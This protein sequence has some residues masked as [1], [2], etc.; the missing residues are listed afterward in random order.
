MPAQK[1]LDTNAFPYIVAFGKTPEDITHYYIAVEN[2]LIDVSKG[3]YQ[4]ALRYVV[5]IKR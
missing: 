5:S 1:D 2:H 4:F 3:I